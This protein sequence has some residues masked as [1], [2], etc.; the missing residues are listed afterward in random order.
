[1]RSADEFLQQKSL[2]QLG[3]LPTETPHPATSDLS[4]W[5]QSDLSRALQ[6][7]RGVD[8][9]AL[10]AVL[11]RKKELIP[12]FKTVA[13]TLE[14]GHRI[15]LVG[16]GATGRL[17]LS[18]EFLW[19]KWNPG[20]GQ[21]LSLMAGGDVALVH[22][23]EGFEDFPAYGARHLRQLGFSANDLLIGSTEGGE[24]PYVI[25]AVEEAAGVSRRPPVFFVLQSDRDFAL[26]GGALAS[27]ADRSPRPSPL[28]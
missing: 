16:C 25:G 10:R 26:A 6:V 14:D 7:M 1:M 3:E 19:R 21:V 13:E 12:F 24:T 22:S 20:S 11:G 5:A 4:R 27:R 23:L 28:S 18:L 15:F 2:F 17:S 9:T 8:A